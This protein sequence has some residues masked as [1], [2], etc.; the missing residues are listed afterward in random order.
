MVD[1]QLLAEAISRK[2]LAPYGI[3]YS[4]ELIAPTTAKGKGY[5]GA[6]LDEQGRPMTELS[7]AYEKDGKLVSHPLLVPS[8]TKKEI[9][10]LKMGGEPTPDIY[11]KAQDWAQ[12]RIGAGQS[13]F[14]T[15]QDIKFPVPQ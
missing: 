5:F 13:P 3:R 9:D 15:S 10:L 12:K 7:S 8:L 6:V 4:E 14:A 2:G 11:Q 1:Y